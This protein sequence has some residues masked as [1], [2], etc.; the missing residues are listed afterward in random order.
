ME[1]VPI[2]RTSLVI[3][4]LGT[5]KNKPKKFSHAQARRHKDIHLVLW[6]YAFRCV[7]YIYNTVPSQDD[8]HS[9]AF[10]LN[11]LQNDLKGDNTI[12]KMVTLLL[13]GCKLWCLELFAC[14]ISHVLN[15]ATCLVSPQYDSRYHDFFG[16]TCYL[17]KVFTNI[18]WRQFSRNS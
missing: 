10:C 6:Q 3:K 5:I 12:Q 2:S 8:V 7:A 16:T 11:T 13:I 9:G 4:Q 14:N 17:L 1:E 15:I 18:Q